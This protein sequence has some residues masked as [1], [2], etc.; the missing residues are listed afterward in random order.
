MV[1]DPY[2]EKIIKTFLA[3]NVIYLLGSDEKIVPYMSAKGAFVLSL[4]PP[5]STPT[6]SNI[7]LYASFSKQ[8]LLFIYYCRTLAYVMTT[9]NLIGRV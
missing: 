9:T 8:P 6:Y 7:S 1:P 4:A 5:D 2:F 3:C